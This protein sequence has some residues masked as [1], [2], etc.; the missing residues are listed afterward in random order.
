MKIA[1][2][3]PP[4]ANE[5]A[6]LL[7]DKATTLGMTN[8]NQLATRLDIDQDSVDRILT[9]MAKPNGRT[10]TRYAQF[11]HPTPYPYQ[12]G[13]KTNGGGAVANVTPGTNGA[14]RRPSKLPALLPSHIAGLATILQQIREHLELI[15]S[16]LPSLYSWEHQLRSQDL[17]QLIQQLITAPE[18]TRAFVRTLLGNQ[19]LPVPPA[20]ASSPEATRHR[21]TK[22]TRAPA[23]G[24]QG[25]TRSKS[26]VRQKR[27]TTRAG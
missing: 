1:D 12:P 13:G 15:S 18:E 5:L 16:V 27:G 20:R 6:R 11:L 7:I 17:E 4:K 3:R 8:S 19:S 24:R 21:T 25:T 14:P 23:R 10:V 22:P 26:H 2:I 9:T